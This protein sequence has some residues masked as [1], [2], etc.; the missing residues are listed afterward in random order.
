MLAFLDGG[1]ES[2]ELP[3]ELII[4]LVLPRDGAGEDETGIPPAPPEAPPV[5]PR[6]AADKRLFESCEF[7]PARSGG[8]AGRGNVS[9]GMASKG[10]PSALMLCVRVRVC[11]RVC[12]RTH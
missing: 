8:N 2:R 7:D 4:P 11:V 6:R 12:V 10:Q 9:K 5:L 3:G 1:G